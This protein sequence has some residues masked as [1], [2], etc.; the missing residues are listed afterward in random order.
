MPYNYLTYNENLLNVGAVEN[1]YFSEDLQSL[2]GQ[3][4]LNE[5]QYFGNS[6]TDVIEYTLYNSRFEFLDFNNIL[7]KTNYSVLQGSYKDINQENKS[8]TFSKPFTNYVKFNNKILLDTQDHITSIGYGSGLYYILYNFVRNVAGTPKNRLVIKEISPSR[9]ELKLS[10]TFTPNDSEEA[11]LTYSRSTAFSQKKFLF[12]Q[13]YDK[14]VEI[15][16]N[17]PIEDTFNSELILNKN[18]AYSSLGFNKDSELQEFISSTYKGFDKVIKYF[19][20]GSSETLIED[21]SKFDGVET[22]LINFINTYNDVPFSKEDILLSFETIITKV[23]Q[24][25]ILQKTT[26]TQRNL[27]STVNLFVDVLFK[28]YLEGKISELLDNYSDRFF[29][30]Y[31]NALNFGNGS[32]LKILNHSSYINQTTG[33]TNIKVKLDSPLPT[34]F[35]L[36]DV[37]WI[38]NISIS[39]IL[40]K[41]NIFSKN[42]SKKVFLNGV[43]F[44]VDVDISKVSNE[45]L[46]SEDVKSINKSKTKLKKKLNDLYIDY[47]KFENFVN[48]SSAEI[49]SKIAKNKI[50]EFNSI[51]DRLGLISKSA[52]TSNV[53]IS[54]SYSEEYTDLLN[55][56]IN[57]LETFDDYESYLFFDKSINIDEKILDGVE[58]DKNN[59]DSLI[60]QLP[61]YIQLDEQSSEYILFSSMVGHFFDNIMLYIKKFPKTYPVQNN[62]NG[63]PREY[64]DELLNSFNWNTKNLKFQN[65]DESQYLLDSTQ[66][67]SSFSS[68]YYDYGKSILN[69]IA[70]DL[71]LIYKSKGTLNSIELIRN[72]FGI[73]SS[74]IDIK[75]YGSFGRLSS[76]EQF[77]EFEDVHYLTKFEK[78]QYIKFER[79]ENEYG[80][81]LLP[82]DGSIIF[83][84]FIE[85]YNGVGDFNLSFKFKDK[86]YQIN[87]K[88]S[89][90]KKLR[91]N[92]IDWEIFVKKEKS[93][94][95]GK[96]IF[97]MKPAE[98]NITSS[99]ISDELPIFNK[100]LYTVSLKREFLDGYIFDQFPEVLSGSL[101]GRAVYKVFNS[102]KY[103]PNNYTLT[104]NQYDGYLNNFKSK[105]SKKILYTQN[106]YFSSGSYYIGNFSSSADFV[107]NIDKIKVFKEPSTDKEINEHSYNLGSIS[108]KNKEKLYEE[109]FYLWSFDTPQNLWD[110]GSNYVLVKNQNEYFKNNFEAYNFKNTAIER[111]YPNCTPELV[112]KFPYQF[113]KVKI[114]QAINISN[115]G[116]NY[117]NNSKIEKINEFADSV[118]TPYDN[119]TKTYDYTGD[120]SNLVG[121]YIS[122]YKYLNTKIEDF[123]GNDGIIDDIG[124]PQYFFDKEFTSLKTKQKQFSNLNKKYIYPQEFYSTYKFYVD[125][126]VFDQIK[127]LIP[128]RASL[129]RGL[130]LE[131]SVLEK[132]RFKYSSINISNENTI[133]ESFFN[134]DLSYNVS[135]SL[136][137]LNETTANVNLSYITDFKKM[138]ETNRFYKFQIPDRIDDRDFIYSKYGTN[139]TLADNI[140]NTNILVEK[141]NLD[142]FVIKNDDGNIIYF[143]SSYKNVEQLDNVSSDFSSPYNGDYDSGYSRNHIS[144]KSL[145]G[146]RYRYNALKLNENLT[147]SYDYIKGQ[148]NI[149]TTIN[150][151]GDLNY[152]DPVISIGGYLNMELSSSTFPA[153]GYVTDSNTFVKTPITASLVNSSS[154]DGWIN[155]L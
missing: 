38:S 68:S 59:L 99:I 130:L 151:N 109:L 6:D 107:G 51:S 1:S 126:S 141:N 16:K 27:D 142:Y 123:L 122:P 28:E 29:G 71:P 70:N 22:Q 69:R 106:Q 17:N 42:I 137:D 112:T 117:E 65:S 56:Q 100:E 146:G 46:K 152:S 11:S 132:Q 76:K 33:L 48:Y 91:N 31:K 134:F 32:L 108:T 14:L 89:L 55:S 139:F 82:G 77:Y 140:F 80:N 96:V 124:D 23:C 88:I 8:Y 13:I 121:F 95:S 26:L 15:I 72:I 143:T 150:R 127:N 43:N 84:T 87:D 128:S 30:L 78:D 24:D 9:T 25:R 19:K 104:I 102:D 60:N 10:L 73:D 12:L 118:F 7:P 93:E 50:S 111:P 149:N 74:L 125:F 36:K 39:P 81:I 35:S 110:S 47:S 114:K 52:S 44:D 86:D 63:F 147:Q 113:D 34:N 37:C 148:N 20:E 53:L 49:R 136:Y 85:T 154:L 129:K 2:Y 90:V 79:K 54:S 97:E 57:L 135:Q 105:K 101:F 153:N 67:S 116:P 120:D 40:F 133:S 145:S 64:I 144:K 3:T 92:K 155:N 61:E 4:F 5:E 83:G 18:S 66:I 41:S 98:S 94:F 131:P 21:I 115:Y 62:L 138:Y 103:A 45:T 75:E 58:Y 119:S